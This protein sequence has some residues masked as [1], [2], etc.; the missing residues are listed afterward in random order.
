MDTNFIRTRGAAPRSSA[1]TIYFLV[2]DKA[3]AELNRNLTAGRSWQTFEKAL[4]FK[5]CE[6]VF[7]RIRNQKN[8]REPL[9][10]AYMAMPGGIE[11]LQLI[12]VAKD[13]GFLVLAARLSSQRPGID[14]HCADFLMVPEFI[15]GRQRPLVTSAY[16]DLLE[17]LYE[18]SPAAELRPRQA[19]E[20]IKNW[21]KYLKAIEKLTKDKTVLLPVAWKENR[22][23]RKRGTTMHFE[24]DWKR[25]HEQAM[26][27]F[28]KIPD[29][30]GLINSEVGE[31]RVRLHWATQPVWE[32]AIQLQIDQL[33]RQ[34]CL[35]WAVS[36]Q[37]ARWVVELKIAP[38]YGKSEA[39]EKRLRELDSALR[40]AGLDVSRKEGRYRWKS[41]AE[42]QQWHLAVEAHADVWSHSSAPKVALK[43]SHPLQEDAGRQVIQRR[44]A[45][46]LERAGAVV[47]SKQADGSLGFS[48]PANQP[49]PVPEDGNWVLGQVEVVAQVQRRPQEA[50][51]ED[52]KDTI[53]WN[54]SQGASREGDRVTLMGKQAADLR[55]RYDALREGN[56]AF[57]FPDW[58]TLTL[59]YRVD[60]LILSQPE[61]WWAPV[62]QAIKQI[63]GLT[64]NGLEV[65]LEPLSEAELGKLRERIQSVREGL[66]AEV[67]EITCHITFHQEDNKAIRTALQQG[68][69]RLLKLFGQDA[70]PTVQQEH[71]AVWLSRPAGQQIDKLKPLLDQV[72][73]KDLRWTADHPEGFFETILEPDPKARKEWAEERWGDLRGCKI[74]FLTPAQHAEYLKEIEGKGGRYN[75]G[76]E[77]G[78]LRAFQNGDPK[79][80]VEEGAEPPKIDKVGWLLPTFIGDLAQIARLKEAMR[81]LLHPQGGLPIHPRLGQFIFQ[82]NLAR[83]ISVNIDVRSDRDWQLRHAL[84]E[85]ELNDKQREAVWKALHAEDM[86]LVQGPPGT[87]K[88]TVIAEIIW[89]ALQENPD[90]RIL[91]S[92][93]SHLAV[94]NALE[95]LY[96]QNLIRPLRVAA[97]TGKQVEPEGRVYFAEVIEAWAKARVGSKEELENADNAVSRWIK[98]IHEAVEPQVPFA[99][100]QQRWREMLSKPSPDVK[101]FM[102]DLYLANVNVVAATCLECGNSDFK[103]QY[104]TQG[105]DYV[106]VDEAS[107]ATPPELMVP[108][109]LARRVIIIGDHKQLPPMVDEGELKEVLEEIGE[110]ELARE[111]EEFKISQFEKLFLGTDASLHVTLNTQYRM[112]D[113]IMRVINPFYEDEGGLVCGILDKMDLPDLRERGSRWHGLK[114]PQLI[115]DDVHLIWVEVNTPEIAH[116]PGYSNDG[117]VEA[118]Q[119]VIAALLGSRGWAEYNSHF[120]KEEDKEI[121]LVS[122][123]GKQV[124]K[125]REVVDE[126]KD[127]VP[128]R[129]RT[130]DKFQG[131]ERNILIVSTVRSDTQVQEEARE[132]SPAAQPRPNK[133][134]GFAKDFRRVNVAFSRA[135][136]LLVIVGNEGHFS[137]NNEIYQ[138]IKR[139]VGRYGRRIDFTSLSP[140]H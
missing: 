8:P 26:Q 96:K 4:Q 77:L 124:E 111:I 89:Q 64:L 7:R 17:E 20:E 74:K 25:W 43:L 79:V 136:R 80:L 53:K 22:Y 12:I 54:N 24:L 57:Q 103:K 32:P 87:G 11:Q 52:D 92:S 38:L 110:V 91:I 78:K 56:P 62:R 82:P 35:Q 132:G 61:Q 67:A 59:Q 47:S 58:S 94:D 28:E 42:F 72:C 135:R 112:H 68:N 14:S 29:L 75:G 125:L 46:E 39:R 107:K 130:V 139:V 65:R 86:V 97:R 63:S 13:A 85:G 16:Y 105:F 2:P 118:V 40:A 108:L 60:L 117:E 21:D 95:R 113:H 50:T 90:Q 126:F 70:M 19:N 69:A 128:I 84:I 93:Q 55:R 76:L 6:V 88:T 121:G 18:L 134:I 119:Q 15:M 133:D 36:P 123:Y 51:G 137:R 34:S 140:Q 23:M 48:L 27:E 3:I 138:E 73:G 100:A 81:L 115:D 109:V 49:F 31:D 114:H 10:Q 102:K 131:M 66:L 83:P 9:W 71:I 127:R 1:P 33:L 44:L 5:E 120:T 45:Q 98:R 101:G 122:F 104:A 41:W 116:K 30:D 99:K 37:A 129:L 106:I